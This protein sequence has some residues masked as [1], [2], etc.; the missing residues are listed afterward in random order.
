MRFDRLDE[1]YHLRHT[2]TLRDLFGTCSGSMRG[3]C[4]VHARSMRGPCGVH[5]GS[6]RDPRKGNSKEIH[7]KRK[8][9]QK[10]SMVHEISFNI[11][12]FFKNVQIMQNS[13]VHEN[14]DKLGKLT[15][16]ASTKL[17]GKLNGNWES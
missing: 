12:C 15:P 6:M 9:R 16:L 13:M 5:A 3:P 7:I 14:P 1:I 8:L 17:I 4:E 11:F 2:L 10:K